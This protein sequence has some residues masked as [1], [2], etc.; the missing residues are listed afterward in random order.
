MA[1]TQTLFLRP[2][3]WALLL[4]VVIGGG[5]YLGGKRIEAVDRTPTTIAVTGEGKI[6]AAPD[7]A[8]LTF[9]VQTGRKET[10]KDAMASLKTGMDAVIA[11]VKGAGVA[12]KDISTDQFYLNPEYDWNE[13]IQIPRGYQ[14]QETLR[15]KVRDLDK[16]SDVLAAA[17]N[18]GANQAGNVNFTIDDPEEARSEA[19]EK[20]IAQAQEKARK[21]AS[22]LGMR[23][24]KVKGFSEGGGVVPPVPYMRSLATMES[25]AADQAIPLPAGEQDVTA[26]VTLTYELK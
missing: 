12:E 20:A 8:E 3:V 10:A 24:G 9:G 11:A 4:A 13:G 22:D 19:R 23:L 21:L 18:A 7:I 5:F 16:V 15:V 2:P 17:T 6:S 25:G 1:D 14:A 26:Q